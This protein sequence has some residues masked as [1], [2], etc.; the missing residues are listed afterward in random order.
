MTSGPAPGQNGAVVPVDAPVD[1]PEAVDSLV[2]M[3]AAARE[4]A[5]LAAQQ[6]EQVKAANIA[7]AQAVPKLP[8]PPA[9]QLSSPG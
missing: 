8:N 3:A 7:K 9:T 4:A 6:D 2:A 1:A 5:E